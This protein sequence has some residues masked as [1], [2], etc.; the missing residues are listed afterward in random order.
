MEKRP[1]ARFGIGSILVA[2][3]TACDATAPLELASDPEGDSVALP[4]G[5]KADP[6]IAADVQAGRPRQVLVMLSER[7]LRFHRAGFAARIPE[8][9]FQSY[10]LGAQRD[11]AAVKTQALSTAGPGATNLRIFDNLPVMH[12]RI[13]SPSALAALEANPEVVALVEDHP[14]YALDTAT[15]NLSL[16]GQ[17]VAA[18]AGSLGANTAVAVLDTGTDYTRAPFKCTAPG[19][20]AACPVVFAKDFAKED[21]VADTNRFHGTNV[22][23]VVLAVA[24]STKIIAL[25]VFE[26]EQAYTSVILSAIDWCITNKSKYNIAAINLS[27]GSGLYAS[28]C[29]KDAFAPAVAA[30][31]AA[32]I[33]T[34]AASGNN[35]S[36]SGISSPACVPGAVAVGAVYDRN[37]GSLLTSVCSDATTAADKLACFSNSNSL[38]T[39]LAPG[40]GVTAAG[41]TMSGTSQSSP[42]VAGAIALLASA[43]PGVAPDALVT[44]LTTSRT[45]ITDARNKVARPR[46]DLPAALGQV[47]AGGGGSGG[48]AGTGG[49]GGARSSITAGNAGTGG[50]GGAST[51]SKPPAPSGT[52]L[53][54]NGDAYTKSRS[55]TVNVTTTSGVATQVCLSASTTCSSWKTY[56]PSVAFTLIAGDGNKTVYVWWKNSSGVASDNPSSSS[57]I[58]D[59]TAP[60]NGV[61]GIAVSRG[62]ATLAWNGFADLG[63]GLAS[64]KLVSS[65]SALANCSRGAL[66]YAGTER[67]FKT[68]NLPTGTTHFRVC[69]IDK[70]GNISTGVASSAKVTAK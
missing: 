35:A 38:L 70:V 60:K 56:G 66:L 61:I 22:S 9:E 45:S 18:T 69:A 11:L 36:S 54:N 15:P 30:A 62:V 46:L 24:P 31:K 13:D 40:V 20:P 2:A 39:L 59:A 5:A 29:A 33:L 25:D 50:T 26:G 34:A 21:S 64:Y 7:A 27:L 63:S 8:F 57:I 47:S 3:V 23:G 43:F 68:A 52:V 51:S 12:V 55:V 53:I 6:S 49:T 16:I 4:A 28:A 37:V 58:L 67:V 44:R 32:G 42:H 19:A 14:M 65:T 1:L 41:V 48:N 10:L 17:P